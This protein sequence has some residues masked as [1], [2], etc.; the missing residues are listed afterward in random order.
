MRFSEDARNKDSGGNLG[1][2]TRDRVPSDF[3]DNVI[4]ISIGETGSPFKTSLGWHIVHVIGRIDSAKASLDALHHE[5]AAT[6][7]VEKRQRAI[8]ALINHLKSKA[9]IRYTGQFTW[10][11]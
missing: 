10:V 6:I 8:E 4:K 7:E 3:Y 2:L 11:E 1:W 9:K 5:I